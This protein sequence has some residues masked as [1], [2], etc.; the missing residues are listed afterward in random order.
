M[1]NETYVSYIFT[2]ENF[3]AIL[4]NCELV[5]TRNV[6]KGSPDVKTQKYTEYPRQSAHL[7]FSRFTLI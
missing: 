2:F 3:L 5:T 6:S 1:R 7:H 4:F